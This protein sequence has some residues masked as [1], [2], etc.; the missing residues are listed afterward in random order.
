MIRTILAAM[1]SELPDIE[2]IGQAANGQEAVRQTIRL[3]PD[4]LTMDIRMPV[5]DGL[6]ATRQI[7]RIRPTP[8]VVVASSVYAADYNIAFNA[9]EIGA[10]TVIEKPH[11]LIT[12]DYDAVRDQLINAVRIM[13]GVKVLR[14]KEAAFA[15]SNIGPM[16]AMLQSL[17]TQPIQVIAI[18]A[19]TGGPAVLKFLLSNLPS[20]F[21]IPIVIVQHVLDAFV[22]GLAD[23]LSI[24]GSLPVKMASDGERLTPGRVYLSPGSAHLMTASGGVLRVDP[25]PPHKGYRPSANLMFQSVAAAYGKHAVGIILT[26]MGDDG[27]EGLQILGKTGAHIIAQDEDSSTVFG[28]PKMAIEAGIVDEILSPIGIASRLIKLHNHMLSISG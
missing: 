14:R 22:P 16:T 11:G 28:M 2:V 17:I 4:L 21:S 3:K 9:L 8:I 6:E 20:N 10:L 13:A 12:K 18:A 7:L 23:W 15:K 19:S 27:A 25:S 5:M 1:L 26:G 24:N